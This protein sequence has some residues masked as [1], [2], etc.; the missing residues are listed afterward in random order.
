MLWSWLFSAELTNP[1]GPAT[2]NRRATPSPSD[3]AEVVSTHIDPAGRF[4]VR[5]RA[6]TVSAHGT[7]PWEGS[8]EGVLVLPAE[9]RIETVL[10]G[11]TS[12]GRKVLVGF[13]GPVSSEEAASVLRGGS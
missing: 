10:R 13:R 6:V 3:I 1:D 7:D 9:L 2:R 5:K 8:L 4:T 11:T 12:T